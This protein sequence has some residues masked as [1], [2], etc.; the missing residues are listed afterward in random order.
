M[1]LVY[2]LPLLALLIPLGA[3]ATRREVPW[4]AVPRPAV[5]RDAD[6]DGFE[7]PAGVTRV[8]PLVYRVA[9]P[10]DPAVDG[11]PFD[12][13]DDLATRLR[14]TIAARPE[15]AYARRAR[16]PSTRRAS[17]SRRA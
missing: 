16:S 2:A 7:L 12:A 4:M 6:D 9:A 5:E 17:R 8:A 10:I 1:R 14:K 15:L 3:V 13:G 11:A